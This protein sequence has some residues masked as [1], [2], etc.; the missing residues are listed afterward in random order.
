M[1]N[2]I[3]HLWRADDVFWG[4]GSSAGALLGVP[5]YGKTQKPTDFR[6]QVGVYVLY[7]DFDLV[8]VGQ[9][10]GGNQCLLA[11]LKQHR[12]DGLA[13][14]WN[15]FLVVWVSVGVEDWWAFDS[16]TSVSS[17]LVEDA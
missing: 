7:A 6:E 8:Y 1:I 12:D 11:R 10:G 4:A 17:V 3:G 15:Q 16:G 13:R 14:R 9:A 2:T 5:Y